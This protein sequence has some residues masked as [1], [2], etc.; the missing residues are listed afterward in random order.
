MCQF[1][2]IKSPARFVLRDEL[3]SP[4]A[5]SRV[6]ENCKIILK[7]SNLRPGSLQEN[8]R[9][10]GVGWVM[11][12]LLTAGSSLLGQVSVETRRKFLR[13]KGSAEHS[14]KNLNVFPACGRKNKNIKHPSLVFINSV[15]AFTSSSVT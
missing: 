3:L 7:P 9:E 14:G 13:I 1:C 8:R 12:A 4:Q 15:D 6:K 10:P 2:E 11:L 5:L